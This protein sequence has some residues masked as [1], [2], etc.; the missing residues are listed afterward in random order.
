[1]G[2]GSSRTG[3]KERGRGQNERERERERGWEGGSTIE[4]ERERCRERGK[5]REVIVTVSITVCL[6]LLTNQLLLGV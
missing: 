3:R 5:V 4:E 6:V 2:V 1:M